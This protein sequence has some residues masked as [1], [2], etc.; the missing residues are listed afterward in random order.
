M[1]AFNAFSLFNI[2]LFTY[3]QGLYATTLEFIPEWLTNPIYVN[4]IKKY[5]Q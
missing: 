2:Y 3:L 1:A 5:T 4:V